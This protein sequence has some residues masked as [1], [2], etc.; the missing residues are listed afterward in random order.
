[1]LDGSGI[2]GLRRDSDGSVGVAVAFVLASVLVITAIALT[3]AT[4]VTTDETSPEPVQDT[5]TL[6][7]NIHGSF[8]SSNVRAARLRGWSSTT[9]ASG[10]SASG[11][12]VRRYV[13]DSEWG[14]MSPASRQSLQTEMGSMVQTMKSHY[15]N[16]GKSATIKPTGPGYTTGTRISYYGW[17]NQTGSDVELASGVTETRDLFFMINRDSLKNSAGDSLEIVA[18]GDGGSTYRLNLYQDEDSI[19]VED[20]EGF[21]RV[22]NEDQ[23]TINFTAGTINGANAPIDFRSDVSGPYELWLHNADHGLGMIEFMG[24]GDIDSDVNSQSGSVD[25]DDDPN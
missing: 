15:A 14:D 20:S 8:E 18:R 16:T 6:E 5:E 24:S 4:P 7:K 12:P 19:H 17:Y 23:V 22:I 11:P 10:F 3:A 2:L 25:H 9:G 21:T 13:T 1:M